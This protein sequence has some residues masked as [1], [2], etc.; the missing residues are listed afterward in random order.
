MRVS[1]RRSISIHCVISGAGGRHA[2]FESNQERVQPKRSTRT[3]MYHCVISGAGGRHASS[4]PLS[5]N[6]AKH[7]LLKTIVLCVTFQA[8]SAMMPARFEG[9][10]LFIPYRYFSLKAWKHICS[11][12][13]MLLVDI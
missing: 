2:S 4:F 13:F 10:L 8:A 11:R 3:K 6:V 5:N 1:F 12:K 7:T 9:H